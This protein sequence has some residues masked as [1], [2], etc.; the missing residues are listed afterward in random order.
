MFMTVQPT[1]SHSLPTREANI[2]SILLPIL[3]VDK[4][5]NVE[6]TGGKLSTHR[7]YSVGSGKHCALMLNT[8]LWPS[9]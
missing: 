2:V 3:P 1:R 6:Y 7:L 5:S 4:D 9:G 8:A